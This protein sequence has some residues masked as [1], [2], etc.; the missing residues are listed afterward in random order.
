MAVYVLI[1]D[2]IDSD[3][4]ENNNLDDIDSKTYEEVEYI[5]FRFH[6]QKKY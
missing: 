6:N 5:G 2:Q 4:T 1:K 3:C